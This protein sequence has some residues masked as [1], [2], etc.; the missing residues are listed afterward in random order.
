MEP[1]PETSKGSHVPETDSP[2]SSRLNQEGH[3]DRARIPSVPDLLHKEAL[4]ACIVLAVVCLLSAGSDAPIGEAADPT[5]IP[6]E[7]VK[8]PWIFLGIQQMLRF[9]PA[10]V[11]GIV[12]PL[13][14]LALLAAVPFFPS[15]KQR[16]AFLLVLGII[17][18]SS[19]LTVWGYVG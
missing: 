1:F 8:A 17:V 15:G 5:G 14:A 4:A 13:A 18:V 10:S 7:H 3:G 9:L 6:A 19:I 12:L 2:A 11:A 16:L